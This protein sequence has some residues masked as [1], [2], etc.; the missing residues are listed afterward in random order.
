MAT[1]VARHLTTEELEAGLDEIRRA[2][3]AEGTIELI[4]RRPA[5]GEREV[6]QEGVLDLAEGLVGDR[7]SAASQLADAGRIAAT[8]RR[9]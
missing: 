5:E 2:P 7:W 6:L 3:A 9:S 8:A 1:D 4:V